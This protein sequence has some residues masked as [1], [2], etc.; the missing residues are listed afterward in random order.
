MDGFA[1]ILS[2]MFCERLN[3]SHPS[4]ISVTHRMDKTLHTEPCLVRLAEYP[5]ILSSSTYIDL[6]PSFTLFIFIVETITDVPISYSI[7]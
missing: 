2:E 5:G 7:L 4:S 6:Q 3:T 1:D